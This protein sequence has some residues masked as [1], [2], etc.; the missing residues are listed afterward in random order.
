MIVIMLAGTFVTTAS[1]DALPAG[2]NLEEKSVKVKSVSVKEKNVTLKPGATY[3]ISASVSPSNASNK[4][5]KYSSSN[6]KVAKVSSNK[7]V[8]EV[9]KSGKVTPKG[10]GECT[11][12]V[13]TSTGLKATCKVHVQKQNTVT[14][15]FRIFKSAAAGVPEKIATYLVDGED[16]ITLAADG[17]TGEILKTSCKQRNLDVGAGVFIEKGGIECYYKTKKVAY[18]SSTYII[19]IGVDKLSFEAYTYTIYCRV[20]GDGSMEVAYQIKGR[21][22]MLRNDSYYYE[23]KSSTSLGK[24]TSHKV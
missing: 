7:K 9:S 13:K 11:I 16:T 1:A 24:K 14:K 4:K 10:Y 17:K 6:T 15:S 20:E 5:L 2:I 18:F 21:S 8:A 12:T 19:K 23:V 3:Q 22:K